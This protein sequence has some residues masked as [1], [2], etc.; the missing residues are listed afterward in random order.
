MGQWQW[1][2]RTDQVVQILPAHTG[3][4]SEPCELTCDH[5]ETWTTTAGRWARSLWSR[6][7]PCS[8]LLYPW[9][10][11]WHRLHRWKQPIKHQSYSSP[12]SVSLRVSLTL[13]LIKVTVHVSF[14]LCVAPIP[15]PGQVLTGDDRTCLRVESSDVQGYFNVSV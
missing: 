15:H 9:C 3:W 10:T 6:P 8:L 11:S 5:G 14:H 13:L 1:V 4:R 12:I 7:S 2:W